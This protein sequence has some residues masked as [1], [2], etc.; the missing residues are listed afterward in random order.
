MKIRK[1]LIVCGTLN[2]DYE[3]GSTPAMW[4]LY[5]G[6]YEVG[7]DLILVPYLSAPVRSLWWRCAPNPVEMEGRVYYWL[8]KMMTRNS[9]SGSLLNHNNERLVPKLARILTSGKM[10]KAIISVIQNEKDVD[11][12]LFTQLPANHFDKIASQLKRDYDF[13]IV[14]YDIDLPVSLPEYG[15]Y[16][17]NHYLGADISAFDAVI[18]T[19]E[20]VT[21]ELYELGA[22]K[23]FVVHFGADPT[24]YAPLDIDQDVDVFFSGIG[25]KFR[26]NWIKTMIVEPS[27]QLVYTFAVSG[28]GYPPLGTAKLLRMVPFSAWRKYCCRS[29]INLNITRETH[30]SVDGSS[31]SR[32]FELAALGCCVISNPYLGLTNWFELDTEMFEVASLREATELYKW[33]LSDED[34][35]IC[36]GTKARERVLKEHTFRHRAQQLLNVMEELK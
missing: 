6:L 33:I 4:Q 24:I 1:I 18:G 13:P 31:T 32:P 11:A 2:L 9:H 16:T 26:E 17:F 27:K 19:S 36:V 15:G 5:K 23:Y 14:Y 30:A 25:A 12:L 10:M 28:N 3:V 35:R 20:G 29:K 7:C 22:H 21:K 34:E 8:R